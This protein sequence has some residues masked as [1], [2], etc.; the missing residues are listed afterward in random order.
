MIWP[1]SWL[2]IPSIYFPKNWY[3]VVTTFTSLTQI[4]F[5]TGY[6]ISCKCCWLLREKVIDRVLA[7]LIIRA[8]I[9]HF[10]NK[11]TKLILASERK[12]KNSLC[13]CRGQTTYSVINLEDF[14]GTRTMQQLQIHFRILE[15]FLSSLTWLPLFYHTVAPMQLTLRMFIKKIR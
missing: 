5:F 9:Q 7:R 4:N 12:K 14:L 1:I 6:G 13:P 15:S 3:V 10:L 2:P 8:D 11:S